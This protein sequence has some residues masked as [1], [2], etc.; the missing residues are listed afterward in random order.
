VVIVP[1]QREAL[2][3]GITRGHVAN[4]GRIRAPERPDQAL[5]P[6]LDLNAG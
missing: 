1:A 3:L 2:S 5:R 6:A 4:V